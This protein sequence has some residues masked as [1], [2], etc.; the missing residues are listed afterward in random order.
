[1]WFHHR[2]QVECYL[3]LKESLLQ[4]FNLFSFLQ[5]APSEIVYVCI[6]LTIYSLKGEHLKPFFLV[7]LI[8]G[9]GIL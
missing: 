4:K 1:M 2:W 6:Y 5:Q 9:G 8:R 3:F 7:H